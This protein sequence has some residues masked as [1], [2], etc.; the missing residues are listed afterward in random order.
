MIKTMTIIQLLA[1]KEREKNHNGGKIFFLCFSLT[2]SFHYRGHH[3]SASER[4][5]ELSFLHE[6][7]Q[8]GS[9]K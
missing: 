5:R 3:L 8:Y 6:A 1:K 7:L 9:R 2:K 4:T